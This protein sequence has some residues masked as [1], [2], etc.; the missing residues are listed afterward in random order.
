MCYRGGAIGHKATRALDNELLGDHHTV[1]VQEQD[2]S[3]GENNRDS[4]D[5]DDGGG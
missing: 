5:N 1:E 2:T 3:I 4:D